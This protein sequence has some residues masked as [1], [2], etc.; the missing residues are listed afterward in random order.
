MALVCISALVF[1]HACLHADMQINM[2]VVAV[3]LI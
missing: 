3:F 1:R 2:D